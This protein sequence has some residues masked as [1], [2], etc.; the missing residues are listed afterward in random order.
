MFNEGFVITGFK[1]K[2]SESEKELRSSIEKALS[3]KMAFIPGSPKFTFVCAVDKKLVEIHTAEQITGKLLKHFCGPR[4]RPIFIRP[5]SY[6]LSFLL[7]APE[8]FV[9][10]RIRVMTY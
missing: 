4:D 5:I 6:D 3:D 8:L 1:L 9:D 7:S 10:L 2:S